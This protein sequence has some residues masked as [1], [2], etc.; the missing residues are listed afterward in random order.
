M[1]TARGW[2]VLSILFV[3]AG[4]ASQM[5]APSVPAATAASDVAAIHAVF[6][7][8]AAG[9]NRGDLSAYLSAYNNSSTTMGRTGLVRGPNAIGDQ[10][11]AGFW[12]TGR[13]SQILSY[14]HLEFRSLGPDHT[15]ATGQYILSGN[16]LPD[17]TG[18]F[19]TIWERTPAG[20]RMI[21]DHS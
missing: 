12:K 13:P 17:R 3:V 1:R 7:T 2:T 16:G 11:R 6:D 14:D 8:T 21:H 5:S 19:S 9:W 18:W 15:L 10:M 20:W 4:C